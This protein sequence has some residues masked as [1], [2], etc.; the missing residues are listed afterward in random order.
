MLSTPSQAQP[1]AATPPA[2]STASTASPGTASP[3]TANG[4]GQ[5]CGTR[6]AAACLATLYCNYVPGDDCGASDKPGQ[7]AER[8]QVCTADVDPACG[9]DGKT[10]G[11]ACTANTAGV[12]VKKKGACP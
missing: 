6:G 7:C 1:E 9:C 4:V 12:G 3:G 11:N 5:S 2:T 8:P 10:Y